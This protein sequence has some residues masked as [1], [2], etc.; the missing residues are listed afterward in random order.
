MHVEILLF[1]ASQAVALIAGL[2]LLAAL[3]WWRLPTGLLVPTAWLVGC[4]TLALERLLLAQVGLPWNVVTLGLPWMGAAALAAWRL[5]GLKEVR[6]QW[7]RAASGLKDRASWLDWVA[8]LL[9]TGW[10]AALLL[11]TLAQPLFGWDAL[12]LWVSRGRAM[13]LSGTVDPAFLTDPSYGVAWHM[14]YPLLVPLMVAHIFSW[15][16]DQEVIVKGWWSLLSG[17]AAAGIYFGLS[18][19]IPRAARLGGAL[20]LMTMQAMVFGGA[21]GWAGF[22]D[23]P[24]GVCLLY[25]AIFVYRWYLGGEQA[26]DAGLAATFF[27]M[28]GFTKNEGLVL[29]VVG[30]CVLLAAMLA[31]RRL[32]PAQ[33]GTAVGMVGLFVLPWQIEKAVL[34]LKGDLNPTIGGLI[35]NWPER[36]GPVMDRLILNFRDVGVFG[37]LWPL[38]LLSC[39]MSLALAPRRWMG[40]LPLLALLLAQ[41]AFV[42]VAFV[43]TTQEL[44]WHLT[45][46]ADRLVFQSAPLGALLVA[47]YVGG[48]LAKGDERAGK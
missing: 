34:G 11:R 15:I 18:G 48:L 9:I 5:R 26:A 37:M 12:V 39:L 41:L 32:R 13:Y 33:A 16:G 30:L 20:L 6:E 22:A 17:A 35:A 23:L 21:D 42:V 19:L 44:A 25:G 27:G 7:A 4:G 31:K 3:G 2:V 46:A 47:V 8:A 29:G 45:T 43:T 1:F 14:D 40:A 36:I 24:L 10:T 28:A 38:V